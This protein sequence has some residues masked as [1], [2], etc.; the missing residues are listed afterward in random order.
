M[1]RPI[2]LQ[3]VERIWISAGYSVYTHLAT[4]ALNSDLRKLPC[5][6]WFIC[7]VYITS[8]T[9]SNCVW[10]LGT[11]FWGTLNSC[12]LNLDWVVC[13]LAKKVGGGSSS[14]LFISYYMAYIP[15]SCFSNRLL[16]TPNRC[17]ARNQELSCSTNKLLPRRIWT[18]TPI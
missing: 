16:V 5:A 18:R 7:A 14:K 6:L 10:E 1:L 8:N 17:S 4:C 12:M 2:G 13:L 9:S 15:Y 3:C 11:M